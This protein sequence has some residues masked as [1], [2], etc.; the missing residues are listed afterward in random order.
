MASV[1]KT[2]LNDPVGTSNRVNNWVSELTDNRIRNLVS[3]DNFVDTVITLLNALYFDGK[4]KL[5][6]F[7]VL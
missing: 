4:V 5:L 7:S 3:P 2:N 1:N 6:N